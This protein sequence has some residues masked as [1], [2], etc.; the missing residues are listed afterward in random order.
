[1]RIAMVAASW[2]NDSD[3]Q[4]AYMA[5]LC[6][7][8]S[9]QGHDIAL[10]LRR[11]DPDLP[12]R[13][14]THHGYEVVRVPAGPTAPV[15]EED[16]PAYLSAFSSYLRREWAKM[17]PTV[18]HLH[19]LMPGLT[20][21]ALGVPIV[22]SPH[23]HGVAVTR[24]RHD[25]ERLIPDAATRVVV[26]S[27]WEAS[28]LARTGIDRSRMAIVPGGVDTSL[29]R[30]DGPVA[31]RGDR[32]RV[33]VLGDVVPHSRLHTVI[34]ALP[35]IP[36]AELMITGRIRHVDH[37]SDP[38][39]LRLKA[40]ANN[41]GVTKRVRFTGSIPTT[42]LPTLLRS[43]TI[44]VS[45]PRQAPFGTAA[46]QAMA[47]GVPVIAAEVGA[48]TDLIIHG[49]TG[50]LIPSRDPRALGRAMSGLLADTTQRDVYAVAAGDRVHV[51]YSWDRIVSEILAVY[52][53]AVVAAPLDATSF[54]NA[55]HQRVA[56]GGVDTG[57]G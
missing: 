31:P 2:H 20:M 7:A 43:A 34:S 39:V 41:V 15:D 49:A 17:P 22:H 56:D 5:E 33:L 29:F 57:T 16:L 42:R 51:R 10:Y 32:P 30:P 46:L 4:R 28:V 36:D 52:Q 11:C 55:H 48:L 14:R 18:A 25:I 21:D 35:W 44:V 6:A 54:G 37:R 8:L 27:R 9:R 40:H 26:T 53:A 23:H 3:E 24:N 38:E 13:E 1:M 45:V 50:T 47:C 19:G 12:E